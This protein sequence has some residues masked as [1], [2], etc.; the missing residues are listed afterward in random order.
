MMTEHLRQQEFRKAWSTGRAFFIFGPAGTGKT[1]QA[2]K[3]AL[4]DPTVRT[5]YLCRPLVEIDEDLGF[6]PG[7]VTEKLAPWMDPIRDACEFLGHK[8]LPK[9]CRPVPLGLLGG[10]SLRNAVLI[11]DEAQN[12]TYKQIR[13]ALTRLGDNAKLVL[14]GDVSQREVRN[15][16]FERIAGLLEHDPEVKVIHF[17]PEDQRRSPFVRRVIERLQ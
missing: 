10:R 9:Q 7:D 14:C 5:V 13:M 15:D 17:L 8:K 12:A 11:I 1:T 4:E 2:V 16:G 3:L 6:L